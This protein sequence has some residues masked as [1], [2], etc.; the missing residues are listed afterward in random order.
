M[1]TSQ[2]KGARLGLAM[3]GAGMLLAAAPAGAQGVNTG[4]PA[5]DTPGAA[6]S[7][8]L[9][10]LAEN[11]KSLAALI[12]A[13]KAALALGDPAAAITFFGRAEEQAPRDGRVKM[14]IGA[15]LAQLQQ[16]QGALKFF[17][18][19]VAMG[20]SDAEV[21]RER[22]LAYDLIGDP[23]R[24]QRDYRLALQH[25]A[26]A[27]TT[28]RLALSLAISGEREPA[29]RLLEE[30]L[31]VRD[32][33]GERTRAFV[34]AL[35][36]DA[37][38]AVRHVQAS[39]PGAQGSALAPFLE[40]LPALNPSDRALAVHL[41]HFPKAGRNLPVPPATSYAAADTA[42][43]AG[44]PDRGQAA[45]GRRTAAA[46]PARSPDGVRRTPAAAGGQ[47]LAKAA[48][49]TRTAPPA[50]ATP[51]PDPARADSTRPAPARTEPVRRAGTAGNPQ[52]AWSRGTVGPSNPSAAAR[53]EQPAAAVAAKAPATQPPAAATPAPAQQQ[54]AAA[55]PPPRPAATDPAPALP[56]PVQQASAQPVQQAAA[57]PLPAAEQ[58]VR[59]A[60]LAPSAALPTPI[61]PGFSIAGEAD[62]AAAPSASASTGLTELASIEAP[63]PAP[64]PVEEVRA[65]RLADVAATIAAIP[66]TAPPVAAPP[67]AKPARPAAAP[68]VKPPAAKPPAKTAAAATPKAAAAPAKKPAAAPAEPSRHWVQIAGGADKA[69]LPREFARLKAKAPKAF[70]ARSG[71]TTP[72]KATNRLLVGPFKSDGEAQSFVNE[73]KKA[74]LSAFAWTS[75]AGQKI[76]KLPAK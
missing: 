40:R 10:S 34:L 70:A 71:W 29:L 53:R 38:G 69:S 35:T 19:A 2:T 9:K 4:N 43:R 72:L 21:A 60:E 42:V 20:V 15:A 17:A 62:P 13:G 5:L 52:W 57:Q 37:A 36:G 32:R 44:A 54:L 66:E 39:M 28:R 18:E 47:Q 73:L 50:A 51:R 49:P 63:A 23:R 75:D 3:L 30:Q 31:L 65:S 74:Q 1:T 26:D 8:H 6:L 56:Q 67:A 76:E 64:A 7:R 27:E 14:W 24:A 41:G 61:G 48:V 45:L 68:A 12:G 46:T 33:A 59:I 55:A 11:P 22:G 16:P 25:G 58:P